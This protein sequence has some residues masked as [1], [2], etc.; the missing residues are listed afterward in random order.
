[1]IASAKPAPKPGY[2]SIHRDEVLPL[3]VVAHRLGWGQRTIR[4]AQADGL[5]TIRYGSMKYC[6]GADILKWFGELA[7]QEK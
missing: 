5:R 2:G 3:R 6:L 1:M 4:K 7:E